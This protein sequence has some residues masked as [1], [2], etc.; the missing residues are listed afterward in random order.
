MA[1]LVAR[2]M[3]QS[4]TIDEADTYLSFVTPDWPSYWYPSNNNHVLNSILMRFLTRLFGLS[5]LTVRGPALIGGAIYIAAAYRLCKR[6]AEGSLLFLPLF[7]CFVYNP[8]VMDYLVAARGYSLALGFLTLGFSM[9]ADD[10]TSI[11][12]CITASICLAL[13]FN[14]NF[15]FAYVDG[16]CMLL[17]LVGKRPSIWLAAACVLPA[18]LITLIVSGP[19]LWNWPKGQLVFGSQSISEMRQWIILASFYELAPLTWVR[20]VLPAFALPV[21]LLQLAAVAFTS[22]RQKKLP[23][24]AGFSAS[25]LTLALTL[26]WLQFRI[27]QIPL[28]RD[29]TSLFVVPL[30]LVSFGALTAAMPATNWGRLLRVLGIS[31][32]YLAA[33]YFIGCLRLTYFKEWKYDADVRNAYLAIRAV[34]HDQGA[35]K[36]ASSWMYVASLNFYRVYYHDEKIIDKFDSTQ[37]YSAGAD[38]YVLYD[39]DDHA[40]MHGR[41][42]KQVYKGSHSDLVIAIQPTPAP[43]PQ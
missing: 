32:V 15:S 5:H 12:N 43:S 13:S 29:R 8:F 11:A 24:L 21:A 1:W 9:L 34:N 2:A 7:V 27:F 30:T 37:P 39:R 28:P 17:F 6:I 41:N 19:V 4:I 40:F 33:F 16:A 3:S 10:K 23:V 42:L 36:F 26:H 14:A 22:P 31:T 38:G 20:Q 18:L 35:H 25:I